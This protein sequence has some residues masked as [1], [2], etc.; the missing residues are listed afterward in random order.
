MSQIDYRLSHPVQ[1][2]GGGSNS[3]SSQMSDVSVGIQC[4]IRRTHHRRTLNLTATPQVPYGFNDADN[5]ENGDETSGMVSSIS[6]RC[7]IIC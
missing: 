1:D 4:R 3:S 7:A 5:A 6:S 2:A